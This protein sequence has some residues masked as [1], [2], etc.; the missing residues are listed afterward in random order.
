MLLIRLIYDLVAIPCIIFV[1]FHP[2]D[3]F[4]WTW[5]KSKTFVVWLWNKI[6]GLQK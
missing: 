3:F 2:M 5:V 1:V 4:S 6:K